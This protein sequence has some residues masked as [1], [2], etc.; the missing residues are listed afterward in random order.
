MS[1]GSVAQA[2]ISRGLSHP[3]TRGDSLTATDKTRPIPEKKRR[4]ESGPNQRKCRLT[5]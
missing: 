5:R 3:A 2:Q 4:F 1:T